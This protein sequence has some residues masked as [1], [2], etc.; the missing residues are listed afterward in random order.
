MARNKYEHLLLKI[1]DLLS[2]GV[3][4]NH[5]GQLCSM[6]VTYSHHQC[7]LHGNKSYAVSRKADGERRLLVIDD[8]TQVYL[9]NPRNKEVTLVSDDSFALAAHV[10]RLRWKFAIFDA[11]YVIENTTQHLWVF[12]CLGLDSNC[13]VNDPFE[14]RFPRMNIEMSIF[15]RAL[16]FTAPDGSSSAMRLHIK[17]FYDTW[18][19]VKRYILTP[20][21]TLSRTDTLFAQD[22]VIIIHKQLPG[23][24]GTD[25]ACMKLKSANTC[26]LEVI[27]LCSNGHLRLSSCSWRRSSKYPRMT[28]EGSAYIQP[29]TRLFD[30]IHKLYKERTKDNI[31]TSSCVV[32]AECVNPGKRTWK[33][34]RVRYDKSKHAISGG[35]SDE[36]V[37]SCLAADANSL[38]IRRELRNL[39]SENANEN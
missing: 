6:P 16:A 33:V 10:C 22:G 14:A 24:I 15:I 12:D 38:S 21:D 27:Q 36:V 37:K 5:N 30:E 28:A 9:V 25:P 32:E 2:N 18:A 39:F 4:R 13:F 29:T 11:E 3:G 20:T 35:N 31:R 26:D 23:R 34:H 17:P 19:D 8:D 7:R 1:L